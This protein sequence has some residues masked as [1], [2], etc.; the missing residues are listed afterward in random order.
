MTMQSYQLYA[1]RVLSFMPVEVASCQYASL[2]V[3]NQRFCR[4]HGWR[5]GSGTGPALWGATVLAFLVIVRLNV[6]L[7]SG[8]L[9]GVGVHS[10]MRLAGHNHMIVSLSVQ[11]H[12]FRAS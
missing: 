8:P 12:Y 11:G 10:T 9:P 1:E 3:S 2:A 4:F 5:S 6:R 7:S